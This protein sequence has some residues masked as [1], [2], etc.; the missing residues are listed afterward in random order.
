[1]KVKLQLSMGED[2]VKRAKRYAKK[3]NTSISKMVQEY[4]DKTTRN[5][6]ADKKF[7]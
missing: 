6:K 3:S 2:V 5:E 7:L 1:M 4:P